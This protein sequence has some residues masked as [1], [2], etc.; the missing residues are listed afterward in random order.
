MRV[1]HDPGIGAMPGL[2]SG[3]G[4]RSSTAADYFPFAPI[5]LNGGEPAKG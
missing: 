4:G 5:M 1:T 2:P 3:G